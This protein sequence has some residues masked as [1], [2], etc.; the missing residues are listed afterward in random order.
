M[1]KF[2]LG[3]MMIVEKSH[4]ILSPKQSK[5]FKK[6]VDYFTQKINQAK[7][8]FEKDFYNLL[9]NQFNGKTIK[10][11]RDRK[12]IFGKEML[13]KELLSDNQN[14]HLMNL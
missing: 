3:Q 13:M 7:N 2:C 10:N 4:E 8:D 12:K 9:N 5:W 1:L 11:V 6:Y 14:Y